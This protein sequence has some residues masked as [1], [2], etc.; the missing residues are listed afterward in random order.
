MN[1]E[2]FEEL[3]GEVLDEIA[4]QVSDK[5][6]NV[7]VVVAQAPTPQLLETTKVPKGSI[8]L[9]LYQG[10]P[11][12]QRGLGYT[13]VLPDKI[14]LFQ[15]SLERV[16]KDESQLKREVR[17]VLLHEI[18]HHMG[19]SEQRL[20]AIVRHEGPREQGDEHLERK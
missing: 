3:V 14:T 6:D 5:M 18:G 15:N 13:M 1:P 20:R 9:G 10:I 8:L 7:E 12:T 11:R 2:R 4:P 17:D 19:L 16:C